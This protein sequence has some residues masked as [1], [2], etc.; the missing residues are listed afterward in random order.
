MELE[1]VC[2]SRVKTQEVKFTRYGRKGSGSELPLHRVVQNPETLG[3]YYKCALLVCQVTVTV[4]CC[5]LKVCP[6][7]LSLGSLSCFIVNVYGFASPSTRIS[8]NWNHGLVRFA[9]VSIQLSADS[10]K[11]P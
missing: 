8:I 5:L 6:D 7:Y 3:N 11:S 2:V 9:T 10:G 4:S 1:D